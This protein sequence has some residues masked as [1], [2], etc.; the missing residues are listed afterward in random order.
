MNDLCLIRSM[1]SKE[2]SH[3]RAT[4]L[5]HTGYLPTAA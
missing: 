1:N 3:P 2:G 5:L 4:F